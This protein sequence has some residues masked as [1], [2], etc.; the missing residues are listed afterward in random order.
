MNTTRSIILA[1]C[2]IFTA[3]VTYIVTLPDYEITWTREVPSKQSVSELKQALIVPEHWPVYY[4]SLKSAKIADP[5]NPFKV[6]SSLV[7]E[8]EPVK[9]E[10]KRFSITTQVM[11]FDGQA[12][13][14]K[15]IEDSKQKL[16]R[17]FDRLE[18]KLK[19]APAS[20]ELQ[21]FG[22]QSVVLG[23]ATAFTKSWRSRLFGKISPRIL[24]NQVYYVDLMKLAT[25]ERQKIARKDN[26][27]PDYQ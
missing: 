12:V 25:F 10:W 23:E 24:M 3:A 13:H 2:V 17:I 6:G 7:Y 18:W 19:I 15:I 21:K 8:I 27:P 16:T 11:S 4:H 5:K 26:L 22:Y 1:L 14:L 9:K 20:A